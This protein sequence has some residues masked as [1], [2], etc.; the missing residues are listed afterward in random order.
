MFSFL[1]K[2]TPATTYPQVRASKNLGA[3]LLREK[4]RLR[5]RTH[6]LGASRNMGAIFLAQTLSWVCDRTLTLVFDGVMGI[7]EPMIGKG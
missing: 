5:Q 3:I 2:K 7:T 1:K 6:K 4:K